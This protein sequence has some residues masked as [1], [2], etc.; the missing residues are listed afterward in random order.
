MMVY[1]VPILGF[2][3]RNLAAREA[4]G[5]WTIS[6]Y[7]AVETGFPVTLYQSAGSNSAWCD[8]AFNYYSCPDSPNTSTFNEQTYSN[9]RAHGMLAFN[10]SVFSPE[11][12]GTF[13]NTKR[14]Y[15]AG[16]GENYTDAKLSKNFY[17]G[18]GQTRYVQIGMEAQN[19]F[20]H[21]NFSGVNSGANCFSNACAATSAYL[22]STGAHDPRI[23][24]LALKWMF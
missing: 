1:Q 14:N 6:G 16:P 23:M 11:P 3:R 7:G 5:G 20:N 13:G 22:R 12:I 10:T 15:F 9:P 19:V 4:L 18:S 2:M 8:S 21:T 24:Q 17:I